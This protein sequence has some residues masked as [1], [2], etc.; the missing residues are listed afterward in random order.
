MRANKLGTYEVVVSPI[1]QHGGQDYLQEIIIESRH[2][3]GN[4]RIHLSPEQVPL[5]HG[6]IAVAAAG[7]ITSPEDTDV[8]ANA[9]RLID[10]ADE[11]MREV[12]AAVVTVSQRIQGKRSHPREVIVASHHPDGDGVI[13]LSSDQAGYV[14]SQLTHLALSNLHDTVWGGED[15]NQQ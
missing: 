13:H 2:P 3:N 4:G 1:F 11:A 5:V 10:A 14:H 9:A 6:R 12:G 8:T 7:F 15:P